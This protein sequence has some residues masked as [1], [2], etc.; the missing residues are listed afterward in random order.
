MSKLKQA[1]RTLRRRREFLLLDRSHHGMKEYEF[2]KA[3][4]AA[5]EQALLCMELVADMGFVVVT[6]EGGEP[7]PLLRGQKETKGNHS[8]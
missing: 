2:V 1:M 4:I 5:I 3:E 6:E 8:E 7:W